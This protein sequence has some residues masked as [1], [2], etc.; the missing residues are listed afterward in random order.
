VTPRAPPGAD[1]EMGGP[2][3]KKKL[4]L[5]VLSSVFI[6]ILV[7]A[8]A[9][10]RADVFMKQKVHT[11]A[12]QMMG[13][14]QPA[15]DSTMTIWLAEGKARMDHEGGMSSLLL[16][17]QKILYMIDHNKK[18]YA[19]MPLDFDKMM[20]QAAGDNPE[21]AQAMAKMPGLMKNMMAGMSAKVT[22]TSETKTI[23][24]WNCRKYLIEM[25]M[26]MAGTTTSEAWATEDLKI[27]YT[28]IFT[29][30]NAML[31]SMPG[32]ENII[33]EM[34]KI[35]G[36]VVYQV[37][38]TKVMGSEVGSTTELLECSDQAAPAGTYDLPA[39][40][41]KVKAIKG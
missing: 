16:G 10:A 4:A 29:A 17:D 6:G 36:V 38:K 27:D 3:M 8:T 41:K 7:F 22:G 15:K 2:I 5:R 23:G 11:D 32:F 18:Q 24:N 12:M 33:Q 19:E 20:Q 1:T 37:S 26:G 25:N 30:A 14:S 31:A 13:Q 28:K 21:A 34:K 9:Q 40:Y 35:K 39:G